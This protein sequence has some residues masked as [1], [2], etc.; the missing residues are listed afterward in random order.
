MWVLA[1]GLNELGGVRRT[2]GTITSMPSRKLRARSERNRRAFD[3]DVGAGVVG[4]LALDR[5]DTAGDTLPHPVIAARLD[6]RPVDFEHLLGDGQHL[7][8][9]QAR[10]E[11][12]VGQRV[13]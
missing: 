11:A 3:D 6:Q 2:D 9:A 13:V 4:R 10:I 8:G 1:R 12:A 7:G 5:V